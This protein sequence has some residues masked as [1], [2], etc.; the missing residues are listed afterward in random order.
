VLALLAVLILFTFL[1]GH[2]PAVHDAWLP[3]SYNPV[4][5]GHRAFY[6]ALWESG[7]P[8]ERW[9]EP[10]GRLAATGTNNE[11]IITRSDAGRRVPFSVDE[12][13]LLRQWVANGNRLVLLGPLDQWDDTRD[14]LHALGAAVP[15]A[16]PPLTSLFGVWNSH[17]S[18]DFPAQAGAATIIVPESNGL[19]FVPPGGA[20]VLWHVGNQ[21]YAVSFPYGHG[22]VV[23]VASAQVL[24]NHVLAQP[25]APT[26]VLDL[27]APDGRV[28][29]H[30][31]FEESHHGYAATF[32]AGRL[33]GE[34]GIRFA[35]LLTLLG[36][37]TFLGSCLTRFGPVIPLEAATGR[38]TLEF[39]DSIAELYRR[40]DLRNELVQGLFAETHRRILDR[41]HLPPTTS[42]E[43][44]AARLR[45][46]HPHL[47][48]WKKLAQRFDS[49]DYV[50][51]LPPGGWFR[52]ARELIEIKSAMA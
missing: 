38:S 2:R 4:G 19:G 48:S 23:C 16:E 43:V 11:L 40:A 45:Q 10:F 47:A 5:A 46:S 44:I 13:E 37:L 9:R 33:L 32:A 15:A 34:P 26:A 3:S 41:L 49:R 22:T 42:H 36:G 1:D 14:L 50:A 18:Q 12:A 31:Y 24:A 25:G 28:P 29:A 52:V 30:I 51:G 20:H 8:V 27:L 21:P 35:L 39:I 17:S 7:W 6:D